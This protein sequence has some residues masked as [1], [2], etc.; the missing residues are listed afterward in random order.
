MSLAQPIARRIFQ[1]YETYRQG[2]QEITLAARTRF[3][4]A[5]WLAVQEANAERLASYHH[6]VDRTTDDIVS[7][8]DGDTIDAGL[9]R[10]TRAAYT[11]LVSREYN[12]ELFETFYNSV[13]RE[14]TDD[15]EVNNAEMFV[16]SNYP[17][18]PMDD[19]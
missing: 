9:W 1:G 8:V 13:H 15:A 11:E 19:A 18:P 2:Y 14:L 10:T 4:N 16:Y 5:R 7:M 12:A 3:E 17:A 6:H